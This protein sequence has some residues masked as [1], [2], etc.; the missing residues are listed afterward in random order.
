MPAA[1]IVAEAMV[2]LVLADAV[3][4]KFG[5]DSV[6]ET[7]RNAAGYLDEPAG[8][9]DAAG[10]GARG[11]AGVGQDDGRARPSRPGLGLASR[12]TDDDV[13]A[14]HRR[15]GSATSSS[16]TAR[17]T[18]GGSSGRRSPPRWPSTTAC[19][20]SAA[21]RCS[22]R[23]TRELLAAAPSSSS[24]SS[25]KDAASRIGLNRDRPLLLGNP[26]AQWIRLMEA[27]PAGLR[28]RWR[29]STVVTD[30]RTPDEVA[31]EVVARRWPL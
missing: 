8:H 29:R 11:A 10:R 20:R 15:A 7:A 1:G 19:S 28:A 18:S 25:I 23:A 26:R 17:T 3:L 31:D 21:A 4:E 27:A 22:T 30:G 14:A 2:A 12:D 5:G 6:E 16:S 9:A 13:E 24:T